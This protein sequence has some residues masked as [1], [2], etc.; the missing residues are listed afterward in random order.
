MSNRYHIQ[1]NDRGE[2]EAFYIPELQELGLSSDVL[3]TWNAFHGTQ[4][5][6]AWR[7]ES[8]FSKLM[9]FT[10]DHV[11]KLFHKSK[12][13]FLNIEKVIKP[14]ARSLATGAFDENYISTAHRFFD[15]FHSRVPPPSQLLLLALRTFVTTIQIAEPSV[16]VNQIRVPRWC[17]DALFGPTLC[18]QLSIEGCTVDAA[19]SIGW[20]DIHDGTAIAR[21]SVHSSFHDEFGFA[22]SDTLPPMLLFPE[23]ESVSVLSLLFQMIERLKADGPQS[24]T[25][26]VRFCVQRTPQA[27]WT[28]IAVAL[29][30]L[31]K[32]QVAVCRG[33]S[34]ALKNAANCDETFWKKSDTGNSRD[35]LVCAV[36]FVPDESVFSVQPI[37]PIASFTK[38]WPTKQSTYRF[39]EQLIDNLVVATGS[40]FMSVAHA[41]QEC[42]GSVAKAMLMLIDNRDVHVV[43]Q[44]GEC[45]LFNSDECSSSI[46]KCPH[47]EFSICT[48]C[49]KMLRSQLPTDNLTDRQESSIPE[50]RLSFDRHVVHEFE[51]LYCCPNPKCHKVLPPPFWQSMI[52]SSSQSERTDKK[53]S[54]ARAVSRHVRYI[55]R[56]FADPCMIACRRQGCGCFVAVSSRSEVVR[57][58]AV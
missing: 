26:L 6:S 21:H 49:L 35:L 22:D 5:D 1:Y 50:D 29:S 32:S 28:A 47:C 39:F 17:L 23:I 42:L 18:T 12:L 27:S 11:V 7:T 58:A 24:E 8:M 56:L 51:A 31:R 53:A 38:I 48:E 54:M 46:L 41:L 9:T 13:D 15:E 2:V 57:C 33:T 44:S 25:E 37:V 36:V 34:V 45:Q 30:E 55:D 10:S 40:N 16:G 3:S 14:F 52:N 43:E 4:N 20:Y 19:M